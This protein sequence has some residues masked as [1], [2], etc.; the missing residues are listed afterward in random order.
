MYLLC[1]H[2]DSDAVH[3]KAA[4]V[5]LLPSVET[6][7]SKP[8]SE[9]DHLISHLVK[10]VSEQHQML[11]DLKNEKQRQFLSLEEQMIRMR[12]SVLEEQKAVFTEMKMEQRILHFNMNIWTLII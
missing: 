2:S 7:A 4:A 5:D 11:F 10:L 9:K 6:E 1:S 12:T 8:S 3:A